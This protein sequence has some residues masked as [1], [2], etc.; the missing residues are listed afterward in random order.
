[1]QVRSG[2]CSIAREAHHTFVG[3][4][5]K[6]TFTISRVNI[7][8]DAEMTIGNAMLLTEYRTFSGLLTTFDAGLL[9]HF[10]KHFFEALGYNVQAAFAVPAG[11]II[12]RG[13]R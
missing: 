12:G 9:P 2:R 13:L 7:L 5:G 4:A 6:N 8:I 1:M 3:I 11:H 10:D